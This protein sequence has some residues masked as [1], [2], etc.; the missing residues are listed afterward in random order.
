MA[1]RPFAADDRGLG[2]AIVGFIAAL[3]IAALLFTLLDPAADQLF[4]MASSQ[5]SATEAQDA[6][7][8]RE[9]IWNNI[10]FYALFLAALYIIARSVFESRRPG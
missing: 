10:L 5:T 6:I 4:D 9:Q 8:R 1:G 3:V 2:L 7:D